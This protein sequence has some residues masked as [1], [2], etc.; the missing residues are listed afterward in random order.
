VY[1]K[2]RGKTNKQ[3]QT[4]PEVVMNDP[5]SKKENLDPRGYGATSPDGKVIFDSSKFK[6][7]PDCYPNGYIIVDGQQIICPTCKG[8]TAVPKA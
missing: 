3:N 1:N 6:V 2:S 5:I 7:C 8:T 4:T